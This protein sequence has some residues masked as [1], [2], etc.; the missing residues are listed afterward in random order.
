[1]GNIA[2]EGYM[3]SLRL[4]ENGKTCEIF[5]KLAPGVCGVV[6]EDYLGIEVN[7]VIVSLTREMTSLAEQGRN[8][9]RICLAC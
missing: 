3:K 7:G 2:R 8:M 6:G 9:L 5:T 1:M 4:G